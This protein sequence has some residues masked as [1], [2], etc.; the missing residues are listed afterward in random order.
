MYIKVVVAHLIFSVDSMSEAD[1]D[2]DIYSVQVED[3]VN[4]MLSRE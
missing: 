2:A 3:R 4:S 1:E